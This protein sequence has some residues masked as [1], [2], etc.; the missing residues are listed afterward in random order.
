MRIQLAIITC[1]IVMIRM[2]V[3]ANI[4]RQVHAEY[5]RRRQVLGQSGKGNILHELPAGVHA[6]Y[7]RQWQHR[8]D[9][10]YKRV[11]YNKKL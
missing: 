3:E 2:I 8:G 5:L 7:I 11:K 6:A 1:L 9:Y 10:K 4:N